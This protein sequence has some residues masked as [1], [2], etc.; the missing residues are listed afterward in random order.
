MFNRLINKVAW[1]YNQKEINK[2]LP[3]IKKINSY[4]KEY[5][6]LTDI[7]IQNKTNEFKERYT[8][9]ET[10]DDLLPEAFATVKQ[11]CKR[12]LWQEYEVKWNKVKWNMIP[13][14]VQLIGWI[15][16]HQWKIAEMK[17]WEWK[18]L[19]AVAPIYLNAITWK[20][21][22]VVTVNDYLAS[23]DA[24]R[25]WFIYKRLWLSIWCVVKE[26]PVH[27]RYEEYSKDIT[28]VENSELW[29]DFLRDN[30]V[31]T[32]KE[33]VLLRRNLN[34]AIVDEIDSIL[35]D[36]ARTPLI[37][38]EPREEPTN[39]YIFYAQ[40]VKAL[41]QCKWKKKVSKWLLHEL[42][43][44]NKNIE[45]EKEICDYYIDEKT[46]TVSLTSEGI[47]KLE[48]I[49]KVD[50]LY[51]D[52]WYEEIHHIENALRA[53]AVYRKDIEYIVRNWEILIVDEH[54]WRAMQW[55][56]FSE[57]LHQ[58]IEAK[59]WVDIKRES[60]SL[61]TITYQ[62]FFKQY[63][64]LSWMTWTAV[65]EWEEFNNIYDLE[66]LQIPTNRPVIRVD[67]ND[68]IYFNQE[69]K[70]H[71]VLE[72]IKFYN[73]IWQP[74]LIWTSAI[75]TS[76][77]VSW[78]LNK[79][80][81]V[82]YVLNAKYHEQEANIISNS[83]KFK[84]VIVATNMAWRWTDIKLEEWLNKKIA[85]NYAKRIQKN[86]NKWNW[87]SAIVFSKKEF[88]L[89]IDWIKEI[90]W[91][92]EENIIQAEKLEFVNNKIK[93][94]V[95]FNKNKKESTDTFAEII[96]TSSTDSLEIIEKE[97]HFWLFILW[98]EKHESRRID[99]QLRWRAWRQW[100]PWI[101]VFFV[102]LDDMLMKKMWWEK[103]Q[104]MAS[105]MLSKSDM[106]EMELTQKQFTNAIIRAQKQMEWRNFSIRKHLFE[107]DTVI[108]KQRQRI[109][110]IRDEIL[111]IDFVE[112]N[113]EKEKKQLE[114]VEKTKKEIIEN[115]E[116]I[117]KKQIK[118]TKTIKQSTDIFIENVK[119]ERSINISEFK[120][121][122]N[123][124]ELWYKLI[125]YLK[126]LRNKKIKNT[127]DK[128]LLFE[129]FKN[130]VLF[131]IDKLRIEHIDEMQY[132]KDKVW[133]MWYAQIDPLVMYKK[134]AYHKFQNL[135]Y[136]LKVN[137]T[138]FLFTNDFENS[139][140]WIENNWWEDYSELLKEITNDL[141]FQ[142]IV[143]WNN[144]KKLLFQDEDWYEVFEEMWRNNTTEN[145][146]VI[147]LNEKK[148]IRPNDLCPCWSWKKYKKCCWKEKY[149][150]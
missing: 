131:N 51:K 138:I 53:K 43:N 106:K 40:V 55:R 134:E 97:F 109:Y 110:K 117:I 63:N 90:F 10:L 20:W 123:I 35:I 88:E 7:E 47:S 108:D 19:V 139:Q 103:I 21:V 142:N 11:A 146:N 22:H 78:L 120:D 77:Y 38:S 50:N 28:Y 125:E 4:Y 124:D 141:W 89:T 54:T 31:K 130:T 132:L 145:N 115:I 52:F 82:H 25:M 72:Y 118:D 68:K 102:A 99:N 56:R 29:F 66:V 60:R 119:K 36:E 58:A 140:P 75:Q 113:E 9:W 128:I 45:E 12:I 17:T 33:R 59:E 76:E 26:V 32:M 129:I 5:E 61:A 92:N 121:I 3:V 23:R 46:K 133:F 80:W 114:F 86:I 64:K 107:Y 100:D 37:I 94:K 48:K 85:I 24:E 93:L 95:N 126:N 101:S 74:I 143:K 39:K 79:Q 34:Y 135:L 148:K 18:T 6:E 112:D 122:K 70:R 62:N 137:T 98:T 8:K 30:L 147:D 73:E 83:W 67:K 71:H 91:L 1:D 81:I 127:D 104:Q 49:L 41:V 42:L 111:W 65:T 14:D 13:Y 44:D 57:W 2:I 69:A 16:L 96:L 116:I 136:S 149:W 84:S 87:V 150:K 27:K 144:W 105:I 15:I